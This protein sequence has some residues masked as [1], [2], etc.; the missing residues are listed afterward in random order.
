MP[1]IDLIQDR[2]DSTEGWASLNPILEL[3]EKGLDLDL[4][5]IKYGDGFN[6]WS[7][8]PYTPVTGGTSSN[9]KQVVSIRHDT[10]TGWVSSNPILAVA[11]IGFESD[12]KK[13]KVGDGFSVWKSLDY[14]SSSTSTS[15]SIFTTNDVQNAIQ[16]LLSNGVQSGIT[17]VYNTDTSSLSS[18]VDILSTTEAGLAPKLPNDATKY[19]NGVGA[20]TAPTITDAT[21]T[22]SDITTN[23][24]STSKHGFFPKLPTA[25]GKYLKDDLTWATPAGGGSG[26]STSAISTATNA[27][28]NYRYICDT[29]SAAFILTLPA[30][31][32]V[33]DYLEI[34]DAKGT[35]GTNNLTVANNGKNVNGVAE[36]LTIDMSN[37]F[38]TL[39]F[40]NDVTRGWQ[41]DIGGNGFPKFSTSTVYSNLVEEKILTVDSS[42]VVFSGLDS[43][44]DG[45]YYLTWSL[46]N[47]SGSTVSYKI[48]GDSLTDGSYASVINEGGSNG[49]N[50]FP[51]FC[52]CDTSYCSTGCCTISVN[53]SKLLF[54]STYLRG[55]TSPLPGRATINY[56]P[57]CSR[58]T[59]LTI[60]G[61]VK[62]GSTFRLYK[63]NGAKYLVPYN[64]TVITSRT[65]DYPL[66]AGE[67]V[68]LTY[69][70]ATS[71]PLNIK[72]EEGEYEI[73]ISGDHY[74][75]P[76][77]GLIS[78]SPNN[79]SYLNAFTQCG[80]FA[81]TGGVNNSFNDSNVSSIVF[82][83]QV[84]CK[85]TLQIST[86][87]T[88][89]HALCNTLCHRS[90]DYITLD[91]HSSWR[92]SSTLWYSLGTIT[93]IVPQSGK[94]II[95]RII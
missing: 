51:Y 72:T 92:D 9:V 78:L 18:T 25:T 65:S 3:G 16:A 47:G 88:G 2:R 76:T 93:F 60:S 82:A 14:T 80:F 34:V 94:I 40:S 41:V 33:G 83:E 49:A 58:I 30:S 24:V 52:Q 79:T 67:T 26:L 44:V 86:R 50:S 91:Y 42:S 32:A 95:K 7:D 21:I 73:K 31:P 35:F 11:E 29:S 56:T 68:Y 66:K 19:L 74:A 84:I 28:A 48:Y 70:N 75:A 17:F 90:S 37:S 46:L 36:A 5:L 23:D 87:V 57:S 12:S 77:S 69:T 64:P 54:Y 15:T 81:T 63:S 8:L 53:N 45:D 62:S 38:I 20:Y 59:S 13:L 89:K 43:S 39:T 6:T 4:N 22:T 10:S 85:S 1:R 61:A 27:A 71:V 55:A